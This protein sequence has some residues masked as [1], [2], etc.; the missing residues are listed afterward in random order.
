MTETVWPAKPKIFSGPLQRKFADFTLEGN[1][2]SLVYFL[3]CL[4]FCCVRKVFAQLVKISRD[5][6]SIVSL[7]SNSYYRKILC[8]DNFT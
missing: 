5:E 2:N 1:L 3:E 7:Y 8:K 4:Y 6:D